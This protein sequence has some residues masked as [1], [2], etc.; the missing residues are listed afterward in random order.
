MING[1]EKYIKGK[2]FVCTLVVGIMYRIVSLHPFSC[3]YSLNTFPFRKA[4]FF[5]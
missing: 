1:K 3:S 2:Y 5:F 4:L